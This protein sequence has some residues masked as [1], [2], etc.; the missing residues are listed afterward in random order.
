MEMYL[1]LASGVIHPILAEAEGGGF[2]L[3]F[4]ILETNLIN[5]SI[6]IA[7]VVYFG[8]GFLSK[9]LGERRAA[10]E[11]AISEAESRKKTAAS[12]LAEQQQKLAQAQQEAAKIRSD[13][14]V[15]AKKSADEILAKAEQDIVRMRETAAADISSEQERIINELRQRVA[16]MALERASGELPNRLN[17]DSQQRLVDRSIALLSEG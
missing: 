7:I 8:R 10:I 6:V 5:L 2:G 4:D 12:A 17:D 9:A 14:E 15:A 13:A 1:R 11:Q 3:N 16:A